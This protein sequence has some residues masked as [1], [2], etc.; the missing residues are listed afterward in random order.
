MELLKN[1]FPYSFKEMKTVSD[2]VIGIIVYAVVGIIAG[3][4]IAI[5]GALTNWIPMGIGAVTGAILSAVGSIAE[6]YVVAGI[7]IKV[8]VYTKVIKE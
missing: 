3:A 1:I 8:L 2:L 4:I 5:S 6:V 7:V